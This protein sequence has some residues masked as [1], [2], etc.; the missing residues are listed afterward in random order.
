MTTAAAAV[1]PGATGSIRASFTM[2]YWPKMDLANSAVQSTG[3]PV[4]K[5]AG[6]G[7][8]LGGVCIVAVCRCRAAGHE[9]D[10]YGKKL[11]QQASP[12]PTRTHLLIQTHKANIARKTL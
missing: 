2:P 3:R 12:D 11:V 6:L 8:P 10:V 7:G 9:S 4:T 1:L 5:R